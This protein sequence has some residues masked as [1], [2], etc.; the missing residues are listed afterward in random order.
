MNENFQRFPPNGN[1]KNQ[2]GKRD[3]RFHDGGPRRNHHHD[4]DDARSAIR[5]GLAEFESESGA[6]RTGVRVMRI[7]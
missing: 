4:D 1:R 6:G 2:G 7:G 3:M 5:R